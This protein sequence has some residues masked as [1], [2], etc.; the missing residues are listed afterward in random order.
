MSC[1]EKCWADAYLR[2]LTNPMKSQSE[3]YHDLLIEREDNP[4]SP[5]EQQGI[6]EGKDE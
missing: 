3:H 4:C 1:C 5:Q 6:E 2:M